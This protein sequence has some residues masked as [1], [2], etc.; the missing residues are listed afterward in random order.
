[1]TKKGYFCRRQLINKGV[2]LLEWS[3]CPGMKFQSGEIDPA[4]TFHEMFMSINSRA[5]L[6]IKDW[7]IIS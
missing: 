3:L 7:S 1:M 4:L 6:Q 5:R 2:I